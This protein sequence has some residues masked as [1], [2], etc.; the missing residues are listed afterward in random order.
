MVR[1]FI[2]IFCLF[3]T[4]SCFAQ[5]DVSYNQREQF[6]NDQTLTLSQQQRDILIKLVER[7]CCEQDFDC[8][9]AHLNVSTPVL[10]C[11]W[12]I[13]VLGPLCLL[14]RDF[15]RVQDAMFD[16]SVSGEQ[17]KRDREWATKRGVVCLG[18]STVAGVTGV[19]YWAREI[20]RFFAKKASCSGYGK[21]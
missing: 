7:H 20:I 5:Q 18:I 17:W 12:V 14:A 19:A 21:K 2:T 11:C 9:R 8:K 3:L 15:G 10:F 16:S 1:L 13:A 4:S 6:I